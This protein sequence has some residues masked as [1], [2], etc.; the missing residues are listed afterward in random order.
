M[1]LLN[2]VAGG[3]GIYIFSLDRV[4][5]TLE[6]IISSYAYNNGTDNVVDVHDG[7][8]PRVEYGKIG[9]RGC[10]AELFSNR[11]QAA[12]APPVS[13]SLDFSDNENSQYLSGIGVGVN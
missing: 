6:G 12:P 3:N 7:I 5:V 4:N 2:K 10:I 9:K 8:N 1:E 13:T 11:G